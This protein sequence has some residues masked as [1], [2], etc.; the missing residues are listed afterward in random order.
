[1]RIDLYPIPI[2]HL[3]FLKIERH[4]D[5]GVKNFG[6]QY[7]VSGRHLRTYVRFGEHWYLQHF[8]RASVYWL[9]FHTSGRAD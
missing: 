1:M 6:C 8:S 5:V 3:S 9:S 2:L 7:G 4:I